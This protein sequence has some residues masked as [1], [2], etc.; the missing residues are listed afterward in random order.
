MTYPKPKASPPLKVPEPVTQIRS[1]SVHISTKYPATTYTAQLR[2]HGK[3]AWDALTALR[4][5]TADLEA[6][7]IAK[8]DA[9]S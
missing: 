1:G 7:L 3:T 2:V 9:G 8:I 5:Q 6:M 4:E